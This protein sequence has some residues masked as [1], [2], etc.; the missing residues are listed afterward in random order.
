MLGRAQGILVLAILGCLFLVPWSFAS[1]GQGSS[2]FRS[3]DLTVR[4]ARIHVQAAFPSPPLRGKILFVHGLLGS[5]FS[6][7]YAPEYLLPE[8]FIVVAVD[9]PGFGESTRRKS[10]RSPEAQAHLLWEVLDL[11]EERYLPEELRGQPWFLAGHSMGGGV[12]FLMGM[13]RPEKTGGIVLLAP[14]LG[15]GGFRIFAPLFSSSLLRGVLGT[16]LR[17]TFLSPTRF[18][19][20]LALAYGR[21]PTDE[22]FSGYFAPVTKKGTASALL[23]FLSA[24]SRIRLSR[25]SGRAHPPLLVILG[26]KD[27]WVREDAGRF[28]QVFPDARYVVVPGAHHCPMETHPEVSYQAI[29][30]F[31][32][33]CVVQ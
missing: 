20:L 33:H 1:P 18:R 5:T 24:S 27:Q 21:E 13:E 10:G 14:S 29:L 3:F 26:E 7:R 2:F 19:K 12:V 6:F 15:R 11:F 8:G 31:L 17:R 30:D 22:E 23:A 25:F 4:D 32:T 9:L 28:L 16:C